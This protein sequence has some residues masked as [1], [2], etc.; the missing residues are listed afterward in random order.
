MEP[1]GK[2]GRSDSTMLAFASP[3]LSAAVLALLP[4]CPACLVLLLAPLGIR[5]PASNAIVLAAVAVAFGIPLLILRL[6]GCRRC[7]ARPFCVAFLGAALIAAAR[8]A[9]GGEALLFAGAVFM[10][11]SGLWLM[12]LR[13]REAS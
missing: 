12:R 3:S 4:K 10:G 8:F 7:A 6:Q 2:N 1:V 11:G 9:G 5:L 13:R